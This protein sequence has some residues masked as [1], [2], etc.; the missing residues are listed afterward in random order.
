MRLDLRRHL[1][2]A[3]FALLV[4]LVLAGFAGVFIYMGLYNIG[5][6]APHSKLV[7]GTLDELRERA[8]ANYSRDISRP[9]TSMV[10]SAL[11]PVPAS[12][13]RCAPAVTSDQVWKGQS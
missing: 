9:P 8:I 5:A 7:Y 6:D 13:T 12:T 10:L 4:L 2:S 3:T 11:R 1:P